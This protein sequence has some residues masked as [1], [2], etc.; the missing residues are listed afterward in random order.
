MTLS[1]MKVGREGDM[2]SSRGGGPLCYGYFCHTLN[3]CLHSKLL[4]S[5]DLVARRY[6]GKA[7]LEDLKHMM[8]YLFGLLHK[9]FK[10]TTWENTIQVLISHIEYQGTLQTHDIFYYILVCS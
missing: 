8:T 3:K 6:F 7:I 2:T 10:E 4:S 1:L 9:H 5:W